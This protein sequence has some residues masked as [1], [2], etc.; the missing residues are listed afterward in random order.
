ME[1][2][3]E[4]YMR[5][6]KEAFGENYLVMMQN[7]GLANQEVNNK[8][9]LAIANFVNVK[10]VWGNDVRYLRPQEAITVDLLQAAK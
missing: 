6:F 9:L 4:R 10:V 1:K 7:H 5:R 2:E 8:R 3:A